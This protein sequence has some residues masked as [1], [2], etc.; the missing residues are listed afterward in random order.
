MELVWLRPPVMNAMGLD[1]GLDR[2]PTEFVGLITNDC[3]EYVPVRS[4][5]A[6]FDRT[7]HNS[8]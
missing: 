2:G 6:S 7:T 4:Y 5:Y 8:H 1:H 3:I